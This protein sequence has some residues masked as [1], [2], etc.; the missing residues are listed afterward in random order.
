MKDGLIR[1]AAVTPAVKVANV[2]ANRKAIEKCIETCAEQGCAVAVFPELS[3]TAYTCGDLFFNHALI[4]KAEQEL[5]VLMKNTQDYDVLCAVGIP[6]AFGG[7]LYNTAAVFHKGKLLGVVPKTEIP[8]YNEFYEMRY[9]TPGL[10]NMPLTL[11]GQETQFGTDLVFACGNVPDFCVGV[12]IC[13]DVWSAAP[14]SIRLAKA[15]AS[16]ILNLSCSDET[17]GKAEYRRE[18]VK[19]QSGHLLAGY[20]Y[21]DSGF[22]ESTTDMVFAGH[23]LIAENGTLLA[24]S[25]LFSNGITMAEIDVNLIRQERL[26]NTTW[27]GDCSKIT[28]IYFAM[29]Q[30]TIEQFKMT[31][32]Y[33]SLPF[34]PQNE[35]K[36]RERCQTVLNIQANGLATRLAHI[37]CHDAVLALSG[38]L[39]STLALI[40]AV[41]AF[42]RLGLDRKGIHTVSMPC[43][44]TTNRTKTNAER[45]AEE[46]GAAF[47]VIS[48]EKAVKQH[49]ADI[50]QDPNTLDVTYENSQ[51]R[52]RTQVVMD[53]ANQCGGIVI[54]TGDL[55]ELAL[56]WATYNGD[57]M[58]MYAVNSSIP[59]TLVRHLVH[60]E[61][62]ESTPA[63]RAV[64]LDILDTPVSPELLPPKNGEISQKTEDL[65]GPYELHDF[66]IYYMLRYG[67]TPGKI[68]RMACASFAG[69]YEPA[70]IQKWMKVFYRRFFS[71]QFKRSCMP[72]GV[73]VGSVT[74]SPRGDFR[75]PSDAC[76]ALWLEETER[77]L[78]NE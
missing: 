29:E 17:V 20:V 45:L 33:S 13:E 44:G 28:P 41:R 12:E 63:L 3:L 55:S 53:L 59:K 38:G 76:A 22:G 2:E 48:I 71:Q 60:Y 23:D 62:E 40:V 58:S 11:A 21:A 43:F 25:Q 27:K 64:L 30:R 75:M 32:H 49:F 54:G 26:R 61:A 8:N 69:S 67:F 56:G 65:V 57:H 78:A 73:K 9:F 42:D 1:V 16:I 24:E 5:R 50:G 34:I 7:S 77:L 18:L 46:Y 4:L 52:E 6:L 19:S 74:L 47:R 68:F 66:F 14:P 37:G 15:G 35:Q 31:R 36:R 39:D 51:A 72:D 10:T 70:V